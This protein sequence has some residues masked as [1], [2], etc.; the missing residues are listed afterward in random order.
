M[1]FYRK[2][3]LKTFITYIYQ[4]VKNQNVYEFY[5]VYL[6]RNACNFT[7]YLFSK[8]QYDFVELFFFMLYNF[9]KKF[10]DVNKNY[11]FVSKNLKK[12]VFDSYLINVVAN[13]ENFYIKLFLLIIVF[14][15]HN[16]RRTKF[17]CQ[18]V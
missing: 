2:Y 1:Y 18:K 5:N 10:L 16:K 13:R 6:F 9:F 14:I 15:I 3:Y 7:F 8:F 4:N 11:L 17:A 12:I